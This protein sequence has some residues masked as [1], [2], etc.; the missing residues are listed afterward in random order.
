MPSELELNLA[1]AASVGPAALVIAEQFEKRHGIKVRVH[2][3]ASSLV[4]RQIASGLACDV[5]I[6]AY[7]EWMD[8]L[9]KQKL[10]EETTRRHLLGNRLVAISPKVNGKSLADSKR[11]ALAD[12]DHVPA[13]K[14]AKEVLVSLGTWE[15]IE[16]KIVRAQDVRTA[17]L[18][19]ERGEVDSGIVY[20]SDALSSQDV[21]IR[22][23]YE[24]NDAH[25]IRY[26]MAQ[27]RNSN[28]RAKDLY[29]LLT[30]EIAAEV[31]RRFGFQVVPAAL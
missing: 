28:T 15:R 19:V 20:E 11:I 25:P 23:R 1:V 8:Y 21:E 24:H 13:G 14:Y 3:A 27:C 31:F 22:S 12:P 6:L 10:L 4:A 7:D 16:P 26:P 9:S 5:I 29:N 18:W 30:Q 2:A 17:L